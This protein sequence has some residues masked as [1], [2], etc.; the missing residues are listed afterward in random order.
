MPARCLTF[1]FAMG[2]LAGCS[3]GGGGPPAIEPTLPDAIRAGIRQPAPDQFP[4]P[5]AVVHFLLDQVAA[6]DPTEACRA[7]PIL[8]HDQRIKFDNYVDHY[9]LISFRAT[10]L[11]GFDCQNLLLS[12]ENYQ[13]QY[14]RLSLK[15]LTD[16]IEAVRT[17][18]L[19]DVAKEIEANKKELDPARLKSLKVQRLELEPSKMELTPTAKTLGCSEL[20]M[21]HAKLALDKRVIDV[22][23]LVGKLGN[24]WRIQTIF[25][26][27]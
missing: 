4:N 18:P 26:D 9:R 14:H 13:E 1:V 20:Q 7:F 11:P 22:A 15:L 8:E 6:N 19:G 21:V 12:L 27:R 10:P 5:E 16:D 3:R 23:F 24:N 2:M 25:L 17:F